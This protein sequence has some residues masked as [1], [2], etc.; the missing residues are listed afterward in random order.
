MRALRRE[1]GEGIGIH[2]DAQVQVPV[3]LSPPN[4]RHVP[5]CSC[6]KWPGCASARCSRR[7]WP[8]RSKKSARRS[9]SRRSAWSTSS[10]WTR[11]SICSWSRVSRWWRHFGNDFVPSGLLCGYEGYADFLKLDWLGKILKVQHDSGCFPVHVKARTRRETN[12][13]KDGC[14]DHTTG[15]GAA[16]LSLYLNYVVKNADTLHLTSEWL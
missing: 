16:I 2:L 13:W 7:S 11:S 9:T 15:L 5:G 10:G 14:A 4:E 1:S 3:D 8:L 12:E 6:C